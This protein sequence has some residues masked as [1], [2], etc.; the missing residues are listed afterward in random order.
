MDSLDMSTCLSYKNET[1]SKFVWKYKRKLQCECKKI[2][3]LS[4]KIL[5]NILKSI[6][7][8]W[9]YIFFKNFAPWD[10]PFIEYVGQ[11]TS[12]KL[13]EQ[14]TMALCLGLNALTLM[15]ARTRPESVLISANSFY[16]TQRE[17]TR[18]FVDKL[19]GDK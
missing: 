6:I 11:G 9:K 12:L 15:S 2:N 17:S 10:C 18:I 5:Q 19:N 1:I 13:S 7:H 3:Y 8:I 4:Y 16:S 14:N